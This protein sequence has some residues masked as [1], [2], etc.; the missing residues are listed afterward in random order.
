M[1]EVKMADDKMSKH[2]AELSKLGASKGGK[3]RAESLTPEQ[4]SEIARAAAEKRWG[5][6]G[7]TALPREMYPGV[8]KIGELEI[9][10]A[11]LDN[12]LRVF[13]TR[14]VTRAMGGKKTGTSGGETG[15]PR[16]PPFLA[17]ESLKPF[18][19]DDLMARLISP[20][21]Y[22]PKHA[23]RSAYGYEATLLPKV[24]EV[25]LDA[26][27]ADTLKANQKQLARTADLL[28]RGFAHVGIIALVDEA[29]GYQD[30][31]SRDALAEILEQ[32]VAK[33]LR[34]WVKTFPAEFYKQIYRLHG[35]K[36]ADDSQARPGVVGHITN[37]IVYERLA[38]GVLDEL[39]RLI[40]RDTKGR[41]TK[42]LHQ[43]LTEEIG[44]PKLREFLAGEV[45]LL[46][47]SPTWDTFMERLDLEYPKRGDTLR[48]RF[49]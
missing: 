8:L 12:G 11:V 18:I 25:I 33:E 10:C 34:P 14:G 1:G 17:S 19:T 41:L 15:A 29:T 49:D 39:R 37:D 3:A 27:K 43:R 22:K 20:I 28:L 40:P 44:H 45:M 46:K 31:R 7:L 2:A 30:V 24:C 6:T 9:P 42:K 21:Q 13:S 47:Y 32:F 26:D 5:S 36:Y 16:L 4:R 38:P 48:L 23:G 35:W